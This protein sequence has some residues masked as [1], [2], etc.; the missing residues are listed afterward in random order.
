MD[1]QT[2]VRESLT[3]IM[4]GIREAQQK[5]GEQGHFINPKGA[6]GWKF[7]DVD[8]DIALTASSKTQGGIKVV[9]ALVG[10]EGERAAEHSTVSRVKFSVPVVFPISQK[11]VQT[12]DH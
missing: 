4:A 5:E 2:F 12:A 1:L 10:G 7:R 11:T 9:A 3:Q 6:R 8:F